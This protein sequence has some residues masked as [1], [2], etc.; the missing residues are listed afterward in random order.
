MRVQNPCRALHT[1][2]GISFS[3]KLSTK[4][5]PDRRSGRTL[6]LLEQLHPS[7]LR[8]LLAILSNFDEKKRNR[9]KH[10]EVIHHLA[11]G[12]DMMDSGRLQKAK[13][14]TAIR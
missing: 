10:L 9:T 5:A 14:N 6:Q 4:R 12:G 11:F 3:E 7:T 1:I 13:S 8:Y 2:D